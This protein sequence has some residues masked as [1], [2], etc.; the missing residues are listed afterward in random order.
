MNPYS[1]APSSA[2]GAYPGAPRASPSGAIP[3][4]SHSARL[5]P[6]TKLATYRTGWSAGIISSN[7]GGNIHVHAR[8]NGRIGIALT[9]PSAYRTARLTR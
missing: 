4:F 1:H 7:V 5:C 3:S 9:P 2:R 8:L 6:S